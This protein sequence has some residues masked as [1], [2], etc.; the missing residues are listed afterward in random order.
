MDAGSPRH[1]GP[2]LEG[3]ICLS[4]ITLQGPSQRALEGGTKAR[5]Q[6]WGV[7]S[8]SSVVRVSYDPGRQLKRP[9]EPGYK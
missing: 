2:G 3:K 5:V 1:R 4:V 7:G 6:V 9:S 8:P